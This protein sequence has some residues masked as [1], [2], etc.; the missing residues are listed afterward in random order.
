[1]AV[2]TLV[3]L[4]VMMTGEIVHAATSFQPGPRSIFD[5]DATHELID[6]DLAVTEVIVDTIEDGKVL[7]HEDGL[8]RRRS[9][10]DLLAMICVN[11]RIEASA[12]QGLIELIDGQRLVGRLAMRRR[13]YRRQAE[14][15]PDT[16]EDLDD[17]EMIAWENDF[18]GRFEFPL[19]R[20]SRIVF[21]ANP[22]FDA[23]FDEDELMNMARQRSQRSL[24]QSDKFLRPSTET[25]MDADVVLLANGDRV[26]GYVMSCS[27]GLVTIE[28]DNGDI[29]ELPIERVRELTLLN[30][31]ER[32][33]GARIL[34]TDG[35]EFQVDAVRLSGDYVHAD[36]PGRGTIRISGS[37]V[38]GI[39]F[40][41]AAFQPLAT[42]TLAAV[43]GPEVYGPVDHPRRVDVDAA[44]GVSDIE[45]R[46][47]VDMEFVL[48][49]AP[50][51]F[52]TQVEIPRSHVDWAN[53]VVSVYIDDAPVV[54][55]AL[56][57]DQ[58]REM[59]V[60]DFEGG[61]SL[62]IHLEEGERGPVQDVVVLRRPMLRFD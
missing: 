47:P 57:R 39:L 48:P 20:V 3:C 11:T 32:P 8:R 7:F 22:G 35:S 29:I 14:P 38:R 26:T 33:E 12:G 19:E 31:S 18:V 49:D 46:G 56:H 50:G 16:S 36:M 4:L 6:L 59:I 30:E 27:D 43:K 25:E 24:V 28:D 9:T 52:V 2:V 51:R 55:T 1:M 10:T 15:D 44:F 53:L 21:P 17:G 62:S 42:A 34:G 54:S 45:L 23:W 40:D 60:V 61:R 5:R 41:A 37:F 58:P 13:S